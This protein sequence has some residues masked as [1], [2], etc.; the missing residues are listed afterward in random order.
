MRP[1]IPI[2][3]VKVLAYIWVVHVVGGDVLEGPLDVLVAGEVSGETPRLLATQPQNAVV[4]GQHVP[5]E[6]QQLLVVVVSTEKLIQPS[7]LV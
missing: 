1:S 5:I 3:K 2:K 7:I 4:R 6:H